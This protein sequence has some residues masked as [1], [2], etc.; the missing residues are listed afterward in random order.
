MYQTPGELGVI[1]E[2]NTINN[3]PAK[4]S[5]LLVLLKSADLK[6]NP[7]LLKIT[8]VVI[9]DSRTRVACPIENI[10]FRKKNNSILNL[11]GTYISILFI[12]LFSGKLSNM[13]NQ[14]I[15]KLLP[16]FIFSSYA[17]PVPAS[18][19]KLYLY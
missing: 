10:V 2:Y 3:V 9:S 6:C 16:K 17:T 19:L 15:I 7:L 12:T 1:K 5:N 4:V 18:N 13:S 14:R 11:E 8:R